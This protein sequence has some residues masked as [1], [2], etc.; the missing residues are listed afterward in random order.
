MVYAKEDL[1]AIVA[2]TST[3]PVALAMNKSNMT[4]AFWDFLTSL[5]SENAYCNPNN[6]ESAL[7]R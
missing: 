6:E 5:I 2:K 7:K 3:P 1:G 4:A